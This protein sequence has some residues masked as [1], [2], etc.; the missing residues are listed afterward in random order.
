MPCPADRRHG[1]AKG[2]GGEALERESKGDRGDRNEVEGVGPALV[3]QAF[4]LVLGRGLGDCVHRS[5]PRIV[6]R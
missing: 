6:I 4:D 5:S 3:E 2:L 1:E